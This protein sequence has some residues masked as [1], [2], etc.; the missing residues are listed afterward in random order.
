M[1][2][3]TNR[4]LHIKDRPLSIENL[5]NRV[6]L[7]GDGI[8]PQVDVAAEVAS[9]NVV[10][11]R[12]V[13]GDRTN[14]FPT[15]GVVNGQCTGTLISPTHVLTAAHCTVGIQDSRGSFQLGNQTYDT[16]SII[17]HPQYND[18]LFDRGYDIAVMELRQSVNGV[19]PT[20][21]LRTTP[22]VGQTLILVGYGEGGTSQNGSTFDFGT[23]RTG[24]TTID[25]VTPLHIWW[26]FDRHS[27]SN[28]APGDSGG[29][30]FV[31]INQTLYVAGVTSGG[32]GDAHQLGDQ[33]FDT[34][35]DVFANW[36][37]SIVGTVDPTP[38]P[39]PTP[40]PDPIPDPDPTPDPDPVPSD[41]DHVD[42][43][44]TNATTILIDELGFGEESGTLEEIGDRDVFQFELDTNS[45][46]TIAINSNQVDTYLRVYDEVG[47]LVAENDDFGGSLE[48][49]LTVELNGGTYFASVGAYADSESGSYSVLVDAIA[50]E[51]DPGGGDDIF[52]VDQVLDLSTGRTSVDDAI[53]QPFD[54]RVYEITAD[55]S[56]RVILT[57][58]GRGSLDTMLSVYDADGNL[59]DFNDDWRGTDSRIRFDADAG[60]TYYVVVEGYDDSVGAFRLN[61]RQR[62]NQFSSNNNLAG[63][64][65]AVMNERFDYGQ[66]AFLS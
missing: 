11:P 27:E 29:P 24:T 36:I 16:V 38:T 18:N 41:D 44:G 57:A 19:T 56:G 21:I 1:T 10:R 46:V 63:A 6:V 13:N 8:L 50:N 37:D 33:S 25:E 12:I 47:N 34:R 4:D 64:I 43:P 53:D 54:Y 22:R 14:D 3:K 20:D 28:T 30:A 39:D 9:E 49:Q 7:S 17:E 52:D 61:V 32:T 55:S 62:A 23:L 42:V 40:D 66:R 65:D 58:R 59:I 51:Q 45:S 48:S 2:W 15:V 60:D 5:E 26:N 31:T 35:V